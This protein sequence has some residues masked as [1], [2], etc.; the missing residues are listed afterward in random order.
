MKT[1]RVKLEE[2]LTL[3]IENVRPESTL[4]YNRSGV[5]RE[6]SAK[7][8]P[9][10]INEITSDGTGVIF[11]IL[12]AN[13]TE[14]NKYVSTKADWIGFDTSVNVEKTNTFHLEHHYKKD[15]ECARMVALRCYCGAFEEVK[16]LDETVRGDKGYGSTGFK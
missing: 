10:G 3:G 1:Y 7:I 15:D 13:P 2:E 14:E 16:T 6:N 4:F 8:V 12:G 5:I 9:T 11:H